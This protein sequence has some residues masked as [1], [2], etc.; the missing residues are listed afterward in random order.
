MRL[1]V[2][3]LAVL[4]MGLV[5]AP[6]GVAA[7]DFDRVEKPLRLELSVGPNWLYGPTNVPN[8]GGGLSYTPHPAL[9]LGL[10][11]DRPGYG[12][13]AYGHLK[14]APLAHVWRVSPYAI[15]GYG[16]QWFRETGFDLQPRTSSGRALFLGA[17]IDVAV[18]DRLIVFGEAR[19]TSLARAGNDG[20]P[21]GGAKVGIRVGL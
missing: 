7:G 15:G 5:A 17:G 20:D 10:T 2:G 14:L 6:G 13:A 21:V 19:I 16:R 12:T 9:S 1:V 8:Y 3:G 4:G 11:I 18:N